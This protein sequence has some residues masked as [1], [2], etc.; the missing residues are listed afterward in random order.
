MNELQELDSRNLFKLVSEDASDLIAILNDKSQFEYINSKAHRKLTA[1]TVED[2]SGKVAMDLI[3]PKDQKKTFESLK[4][5]F[6]R[7]EIEG[8]TRLRCKD[9]SYIWVTMKAIR[10]FDKEGKIK[11]LLIAKEIKKPKTVIIR[12]SEDRFKEMIDNLTEIRFWKF[13][14]PKQAIAAYQESQEMLKIV[15]DSIPQFI[16]WKDKKLVYL[17]CNTNFIKLM[18]LEDGKDI[19]GK[20]DFDLGWGEEYAYTSRV[21]D[22]RVIENDMADLH[23]IESWNNHNRN[24]WFDINRI[25]LHDSQGNVVGILLTY[26]DITERKEVDLK[27]QESEEKYRLISE[28]INDLVFILDTNGKFVYCNESFKKIM[29]YTPEELIGKTPLDYV[30]PEDTQDVLNDFRSGV[31]GYSGINVSRFKCKDGKYKWFESIG[32]ISYDEE[33]KPIRMFTVSRD[34]TERKII[35]EKLKNSEEELKNLN[36][37]L[38]QKVRE[39][40]KELEEKNLELQKLDK[41]KDEFITHAA[42]E[43]K[44]PLISISGYTDYILYKYKELEPEIKEDLLIV[45]RNIERLGKL[46]NQLLDVMKIESHKMELNKEITNVSEIIKKCVNELSYLIKEKNHEAIL[47]FSADLNLLVD[48]DRFF[49]V[50]SNLLSNAIKFTPENGKIEITATKDEVLSQY[51]FEFKDNGIGLNETELEKLFKKFEMVKQINDESYIKGTGL[52]LYIS[53]GFIE[54]HGGNI[55]AT[56]DGSNKGTTIYFTLPV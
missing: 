41:I 39:R 8:E 7:G 33:G 25:P 24:I 4:K 47:N 36:K 1:Y 34:I 9:G 56:S 11:V 16:A 5:V 30:H 28:N 35:E 13:L 19:I 14:Q 54:A 2:L 29:G 43:L 22:M 45:Q 44:T 3:H 12:K 40:T 10:F 42:H 21:N 51:I 18:D 48:P 32:N 37:K 52:G 26:E 31:K 23:V 15:M 6:T 46:M 50:I 17:G 27:I 20:T 38:E 53:K 55:W 49:Q